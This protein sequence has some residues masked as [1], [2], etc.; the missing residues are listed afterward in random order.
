MELG[1]PRRAQEYA[2]RLNRIDEIEEIPNLKKYTIGDSIYESIV[3]GTL[4]AS[5]SCQISMMCRHCTSIL[6]GS[7]SQAYTKSASLAKATLVSPCCFAVSFFLIVTY[8]IP[9]SSTEAIDDDTS[10]A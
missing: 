6:I 4:K 3:L 10:T 2:I 5:A 8:G 7:I 1:Y 9:S